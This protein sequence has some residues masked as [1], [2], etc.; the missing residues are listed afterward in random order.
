MEFANH[1]TF[2]MPPPHSLAHVQ[3]ESNSNP[4]AME[5]TLPT[6]S[7]SQTT[8]TTSTLLGVPNNATSDADVNPSGLRPTMFEHIGSNEDHMGP[9]LVQNDS[10][11]QVPAV[12]DTSAQMNTSQSAS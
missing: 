9:P 5:T 10:V 6:M 12:M 11:T 1:P 2:S 4:Q 8:T 7:V 3:A